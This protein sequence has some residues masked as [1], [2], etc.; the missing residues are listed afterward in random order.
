M[1]DYSFDQSV[2]LLSRIGAMGGRDLLIFAKH[3]FVEAMAAAI[4]PA[5]GSRD[6]QWD[7]L[8]MNSEPGFPGCDDHRLNVNFFEQRKG[9]DRSRYCGGVP[10]PA[11]RNSPLSRPGWV[12]VP[13]SSTSVGADPEQDVDARV[14]KA[15]SERGNQGQA[16]ANQW[17]R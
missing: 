7:L 16:A 9:G 6:D 2:M 14:A 5:G 3:L 4:A 11:Y 15:S 1:R 17:A 8:S 13:I 10:G 12:I